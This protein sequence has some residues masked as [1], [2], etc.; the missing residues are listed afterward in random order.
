MLQTCLIHGNG[1]LPVSCSD[2]ESRSSIFRTMCSMEECNYFRHALLM[3]EGAFCLH[4]VR[5]AFLLLQ[6]SFHT[7]QTRIATEIMTT[8]IDVIND[9]PLSAFHHIPKC[10]THCVFWFCQSTG[11]RMM[12][13]AL[14]AFHQS[15]RQLY[16]YC[17]LNGWNFLNLDEFCC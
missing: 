11:I 4:S 1:A 5:F 9:T 3:T 15:R 6:L 10:F 14:Q 16:A 13:I 12:C 17:F 7:L 2:F 8:Y